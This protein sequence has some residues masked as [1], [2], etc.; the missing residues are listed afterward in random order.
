[1]AEAPAP[2]PRLDRL[3]SQLY[4]LPAIV[5]RLGLSIAEAQKEM[6][7]DYVT[8]VG[9][10][11]EMIQNFL[12]KA[13]GPEAAV[14]LR[15]M[16]E[17]LAPPRYQFTETTLDFSADLAE[18]MQLSAE[19]GVSVGTRAVMVNAAFALGYGYD[20]RAAARVTTVLHAVPAGSGPDM[21]KALLDR[22][23]EIRTDQAKLPDRTGVDKE[24]YERV[25]GVWKAIAGK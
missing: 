24:L 3:T 4:H 15:A 10:L 23:K 20:Y 13:D 9:R 12:G 11:M 2:N 1:M 7:L 5:G 18:T 14:A 8:N 6:N 25:E 22:A 21:A 19:G 16:L 17:A